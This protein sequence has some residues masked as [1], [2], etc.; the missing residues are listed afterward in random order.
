MGIWPALFSLLIGVIGCYYLFHKTGAEKL[1]GI[2]ESAM[3][4]KRMRLRRTGGLIL[5]VLA[6]FL[7]LGCEID[8]QKHPRWFLFS[9]TAV[10]LMLFQTVLMAL[11][12]LR[13]TARLR[14]EKRTRFLKSDLDEKHG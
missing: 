6:V 9:W 1:Q 2:E 12:D 14:G 7:F 11:S 13:L 4:A 5:I 3:N 8:P 10:M